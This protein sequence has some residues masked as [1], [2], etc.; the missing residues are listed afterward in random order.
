MSIWPLPAGLLLLAWLW[1]GPLAGMARRAFS[2][3]MM[4][5]L[6]VVVVAAPLIVIGLLRLVPAARPPRRLMLAALAASAFEFAVVWGWHAPALHEAAAR[7][8]PV[9]VLQQASFLLSGLA[10]WFVCLVGRER[11][12][13]A[14]GVLAMLFT[15]MH[16]AMLGLLLVVAPALLYAPQFCLG[17][18]GLEPLVDQQLGGGLMAFLGALPCVAGGAWLAS[19][20]AAAEA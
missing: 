16:M 15:S 4:L 8:D 12:Q 7:L 2:P 10:L 11:G 1:L 19:R 13:L 6:G 9:F 5:H 14:V 3:H 17:A 20:L 18:F